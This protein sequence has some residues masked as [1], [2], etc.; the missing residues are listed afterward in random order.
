MASPSS[1]AETT[2]NCGIAGG[3]LAGSV[4]ASSL[5]AFKDN[6]NIPTVEAGNDARDRTNIV[7]SNFA[8]LQN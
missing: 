7:W 4:V 3:S 5:R 2:W 6:T 8:D 1:I